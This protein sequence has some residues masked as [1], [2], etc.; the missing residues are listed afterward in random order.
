M[1]KPRQKINE[2]QGAIHP[3]S[4]H[5]HVHPMLTPAVCDVRYRVCEEWLW[6]VRYRG[7]GQQRNDRDRKTF[8]PHHLHFFQEELKRDG[9]VIEPVAVNAS[10]IRVNC[11]MW[12]LR[13]RW[14]SM[15]SVTTCSGRAR[16]CFQPRP[17]S[18]LRT[19]RKRNRSQFPVETALVQS[20]VRTSSMGRFRSVSSNCRIVI[21]S[22]PIPLNVGILRA[23]LSHSV[24][25]LRLPRSEVM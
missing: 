22:L 7:H 10:S 11:R 3:R 4:G 5:L 13:F 12:F 14:R 1:I 19:A 20:A 8:L 6:V 15:I 17:R 18:E 23:P 24:M 2:G 21:N 25:N 9:E 16:Q